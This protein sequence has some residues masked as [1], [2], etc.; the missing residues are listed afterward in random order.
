MFF[1]K[2]WV[3]EVRDVVANFKGIYNLFGLNYLFI[4]KF[5]G[6]KKPEGGEPVL[7]PL[8]VHLQFQRCLAFD[9]S[10]ANIHFI[11]SLLTL[12]EL[13]YT[14]RLTAFA[15]N[16]NLSCQSFELEKSF[17][18]SGY[19]FVHFF[20]KFDTFYYTSFFVSDTICNYIEI[21]SLPLFLIFFQT[22][23]KYSFTLLS[24]L[25]NK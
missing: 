14:L 8:C 21:T 18:L 13:R 19:G 9:F 11:I 12:N 7:Y 16:K 25:L 3:R 22:I 24:I 10:N 20:T 1:Q 6:E 5:F 2:F 15:T 17:V 4:N 23:L